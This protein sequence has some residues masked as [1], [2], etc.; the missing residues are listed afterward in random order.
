MA[1]K[2]TR[3]EI[4]DLKNH[5]SNTNDSVFAITTPQ[6]VDR[7]ALMSRYSRTDKDMRRVFLDEFLSN[8]KRGEEFYRRVLVEYGDDSVAELGSAQIAAEGISNIAVKKIEDRRIGLSYLEKSSRYV[9]WDKKRAGKYRFYRDADITNSRYADSYEDACNLDFQ[10]YSKFLKPMLQYIREKYPIE[11]YSFNNGSGKDVSF[12]K[13][14]NSK[15]IKSA[16]AIYNGSTRAKA[17][18]IL[19]GLLPAS[20]LTNVGITGNGRAFEYLLT[21]MYGSAL[22]E[23]RLLAA[24]MHKELGKTIGPFVKRAGDEYGRR[25]SEYLARLRIESAALAKKY[26]GAKRSSKWRAKLVECEVEEKA[27]NRVIAAI[28]YQGSSGEPLENML[29]V[30]KKMSSAK[31]ASIISKFSSLRNNRRQRPS[32]AFEMTEYTFDMMNNFGMFRDMH[33]HRALT[34]GRQLLTTDHGYSIPKELEEVGIKSQYIECMKNSQDVFNKI[35]TKM[36]EQAQYVVNFAY[37][38]PYFMRCNLREAA[39]MIEI[40]TI[41]QGHADYRLVAQEMYAQIKKKHPKLARIIKFADMRTYDLERFESEK[42]TE[43]KKRA[44]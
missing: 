43:V 13:L 30:A 26:A 38:Y 18:D 31:K 44:R 15:D 11:K 25:A 17:L 42:R 2:F 5:F 28:L 9:P 37:N 36:P 14:R 29:L 24:R 10:T 33:R 20:T 27:V 39:H 6:Q 35:Q 19:R 21:I 40:R 16:N 22:K 3:K 8:K 4:S 12:T 1:Q 23:E 34:L 41:P 7:G 32:R